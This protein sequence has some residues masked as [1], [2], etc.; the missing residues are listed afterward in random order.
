MM[1]SLLALELIFCI[2]FFF[3]G[4]QHNCLVI[5]HS[6]MIFYALRQID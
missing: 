5:F 6:K 4:Y 1:A 2:L 3:L